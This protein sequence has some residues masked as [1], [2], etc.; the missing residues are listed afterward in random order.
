MFLYHGSNACKQRT[1]AMNDVEYQIECTTRDLAT[2]LVRDFS[3]T[4]EQALR[5]VYNSELYQK[6]CDP[7][8]GLYF[9]SPTRILAEVS[10]FLIILNR[11]MKWQL[12]KPVFS[13]RSLM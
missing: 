11:L 6:L 9:Q 5:A 13:V 8:T 7:K 10:I 1:S 4:M 3:F 12:T 2:Y